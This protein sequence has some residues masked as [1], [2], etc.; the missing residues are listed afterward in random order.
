SPNPHN[1]P[2]F[3]DLPAKNG[4]LQPLVAARW[5]ANAPVIMFDQ[6]ALNLKRLS[7]IAL[8]VGTQD[9]LLPGIQKLHEELT[10]Y[11]IPHSYETYDGDHLDRIASRFETRALPFFGKHLQFES[12]PAR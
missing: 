8:D 7:A 6:Y 12:A 4:K 10:A 5:V 3:I 11:G 1:P 2:R 9:S